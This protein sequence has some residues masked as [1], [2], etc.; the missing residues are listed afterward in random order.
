MADALANA[1]D[2]G[3]V[4]REIY[5]VEEEKGAFWVPVAKDAVFPDRQ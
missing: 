4:S 3:M 2:I 1:V 5:P